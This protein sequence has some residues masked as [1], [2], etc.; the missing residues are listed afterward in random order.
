M[1]RV[2]L[3]TERLA[4]V[5]RVPEGR[6][7]QVVLR[8][9]AAVIAERERPVPR[10]VVDRTPEVDDLEAVLQQ[11]WDVFGGQVSVDTGNRGLGGLVDVNLRHRLTFLGAVVELAGTATTDG[12]G[13]RWE[14]MGQP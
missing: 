13:K 1:L 9:D 8:V 14:A 6:G 12:W 3:D 7:H 5:I 2:V 11:L 10:R 4:F